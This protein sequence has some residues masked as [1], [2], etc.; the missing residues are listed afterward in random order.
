M[1]APT[2]RLE[3]LEILLNAGV[4]WAD[5][6]ADEDHPDPAAIV[7]DTVRE[8]HELVEALPPCYGVAE[9]LLDLALGMADMID[10][11]GLKV[12]AEFDAAL[13]RVL[14]KATQV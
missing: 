6:E 11:C 7:E 8:A 5:N 3:E 1:S 10:R 2:P 4:Y 9:E 12:D 13:R 14:A